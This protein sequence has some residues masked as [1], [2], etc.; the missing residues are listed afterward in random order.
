MGRRRLRPRYPM[1][2]RA[3]APEISYDA[4]IHAVRLLDSANRRSIVDMFTPISP[5]TTI[6]WQNPARQ[7]KTRNQRGPARNW[8]QAG[9]QRRHPNPVW[10]LPLPSSASTFSDRTQV[11]FAAS[12]MSSGVMMLSVDAESSIAWLSSWYSDKRHTTHYGRSPGQLGQGVCAWRCGVR[13][14]YTRH[15][16]FGHLRWKL[17]LSFALVADILQR[18]SPCM[19]GYN[20]STFGR[21]AFSVAGPTVWNSLP[22]KLRDPSLSIDSFRRQLKHSCF[23]TRSSVHSALEIFC[24]CAI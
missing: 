6:D 19:W 8:R 18:L 3:G 15:S 20:T 11:P 21:R 24:W 16:S 7:M 13:Y 17:R 14:A 12:S 2:S 9:R 5:L 22:D 1:T 4:N 10:N 23:Q